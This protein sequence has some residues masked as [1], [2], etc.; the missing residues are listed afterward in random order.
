MPDVFEIVD[1]DLMGRIGRFYT[2]HGVVETPTVM[3]VINPNL[4]LIEPSELRK[5]GAQ[6]LITNSYIIYR[7][8]RLREAA[9]A[10]GLHAMLGFDGP[11]MTDSGSFQLSVYG[12]VEVDNTGIV[13]FERDIGSDIGV[14]LDIPTP[15][16]VPLDRA[17]EELEITLAR[18]AEAKQHAG[19]ML[20]AGPVQGS[21]HPGL[22]EEA[23]RRAYE[24]GFDV[25]PL[26]AVVPLMESYRYA[27]LVDVIVRS[28]MGLGPDGIVH[29]FGAGHPMMLALAVSLGCDLF[30]SAAYALYAKDG[31]YM[32]VDG[33]FHIGQLQ[34]LPCACPICSSHSAKEI[35]EADEATRTRLLAEHNLYVTFAELR[36]VKQSII[37]G[38]LMEHVERRC[39]SHPRML[40][41]L[42][43]MMDYAP[44]IER[45]DRASKSTFFYLGPESARRP[46]VLQYCRQ[47]NNIEVSGKALITTSKDVDTAGFDR[48]LGVKMP[49][50]VF[51][52]ELKET[53]PVGHAEVI[54]SFDSDAR[55]LTLGRVLAFIKAHPGASF[56]FACD[57][58]WESPVID[59]IARI[60]EVR[61]LSR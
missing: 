45:F 13:G 47:I 33:T 14:P 1:K 51:P 23:A 46:E 16:D 49:F 41:G 7:T 20:L 59:E 5:Y 34:H 56:T 52:A 6:M 25:Y 32:T 11:I 42:Q 29:L 21:T 37:D 17:R 43:R 22:R 40:E 28:K 44:C 2:P 4:R 39:R 10:Q 61:K 31:R 15:P 60:A 36:L 48:V 54:E 50:G 30:D 26:G 19:K 58:R 55:D 38:D 27:D 9:L 24:I 35:A 12:S 18:M 53:Y 57:G 3:P 8:E